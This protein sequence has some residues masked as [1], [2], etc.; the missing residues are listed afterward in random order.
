MSRLSGNFKINTG[1]SMCWSLLKMKYNTSIDKL[2]S[3]NPLLRVYFDSDLGSPVEKTVEEAYAASLYK[4][5]KTISPNWKPAQKL[6]KYLGTRLAGMAAKA[7]DLAKLNYKYFKGVIDADQYETEY[8]KRFLSLFAT[9][10]DKSWKYIENGIKV[11]GTAV[12]TYMGID[13]NSAK[14]VTEKVFTV[15]SYIKPAII[16]AIKSDKAVKLVKQAIRATSSGIMK[17]Y[18]K[19]KEAVEVSKSIVTKIADTINV[20]VSKLKSF[21]EKTCKTIA[22]PIVEGIKKGLKK[23]FSW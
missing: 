9:I 8:S 18:E 14:M 11:G 12:L 10:V 7:L 3:T 17:L 5:L 13:P 2:K 19:G 16:E 6:A 21:A 1:L 23:I 22:K 15:L 20:N 4:Y